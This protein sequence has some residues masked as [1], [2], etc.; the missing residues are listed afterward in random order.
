M[1]HRMRYS[2]GVVSTFLI[3]SLKWNWSA[4]FDLLLSVAFS[5]FLSDR[6]HIENEDDNDYVK[7]PPAPRRECSAQLQV[8]KLNSLLP[9]FFIF[10]R[11]LGLVCW[12]VKFGYVYV[13]GLL[14]PGSKKQIVPSPT[15]S[16]G[17]T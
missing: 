8:C 7:L 4:V 1:I 12:Y 3:V 9:S 2:L 10:F 15:C 6:E 11:F 16:Q 5:P 13:N 17:Y 14:S